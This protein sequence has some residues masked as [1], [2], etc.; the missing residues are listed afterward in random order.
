MHETGQAVTFQSTP[1]ISVIMPV[2]NGENFLQDAVG[3]ILGQTFTDFELIAIDDGSTDNSTA[4]LESFRLNDRRVII[5]RHTENQGVTAALNTGLALARG[6]YIAR[7]DA[8]DISL[9]VRFEKQVAFMETHPEIDILGSAVRLMDERGRK[10]RHTFCPAGRPVY[11]LEEFI[12]RSV[13]SPHGDSSSF[14]SY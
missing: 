2:F 5:Q 13:P 14:Y 10:Y 6:K 8:D 1:L 3:S 11:P 7:M 4:L 12:C 9:P